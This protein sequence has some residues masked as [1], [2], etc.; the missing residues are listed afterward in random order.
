MSQQIIVACQEEKK[1]GQKNYRRKD[2]NL[3]FY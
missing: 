3:S 2:E 1:G